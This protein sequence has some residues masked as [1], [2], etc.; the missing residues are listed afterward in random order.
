TPIHWGY[1][2]TSYQE[3]EACRASEILGHVNENDI[4][5]YIAID[6]LDLK[7][8]LGDNFIHTPR[9]SEGIKQTGILNKIKSKINYY[10]KE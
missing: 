6:D 5:K 10:E 1:K 3:L 2:F 7:P 8:W 9:V 4:K